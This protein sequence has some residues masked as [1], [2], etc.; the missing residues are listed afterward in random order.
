MSLS[1]GPM[2]SASRVLGDLHQLAAVSGVFDPLEIIQGDANDPEHRDA[3]IELAKDC[4]E[5]PVEGKVGWLLKPD[6]RRA[7]LA[8]TS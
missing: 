7:V 8:S 3:L 4:Q 5:F 6:V 2:D 1:R